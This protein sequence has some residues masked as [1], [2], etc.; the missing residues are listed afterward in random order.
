[1]TV[2]TNTQFPI[3]PRICM[4]DVVM[5]AMFLVLMYQAHLIIRCLYKHINP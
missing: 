4:M 3:F 5:P 2:P 1:M